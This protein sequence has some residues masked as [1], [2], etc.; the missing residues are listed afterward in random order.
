MGHLSSRAPWVNNVS[1]R[2]HLAK[3]KDSEV[4]TRAKKV[5]FQDVLTR[6]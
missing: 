5:G 4:K 3:N 1:L 2:H 6:L